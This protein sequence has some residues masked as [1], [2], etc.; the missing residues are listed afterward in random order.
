MADVQLELIGALQE[1]LR[2]IAD[3]EWY[4]RDAAGHL[5][6]LK[7]VSEAIEDLISR[8][9]QPVDRQL[10]H[11]FQQRSYDKALAFLKGEQTGH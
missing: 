2:I 1:R 10:A 4:H 11:Y 8:L 6:G 7:G 3:R 9:P 5:A